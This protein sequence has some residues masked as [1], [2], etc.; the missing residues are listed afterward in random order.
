MTDQ[1]AL[2]VNCLFD[3]QIPIQ[4]EGGITVTDTL[5]YFTGDHPAPQFEQGS[6][7]GGY[8]KCEACGC[9]LTR[10]NDQ[11]HVASG[12]CWKSLIAIGGVL[13]KDPGIIRLF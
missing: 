3:L 11:A 7:Q 10:Y 9:K 13:G 1:V 6:K 4:T 5:R 8:F 2:I 12:D